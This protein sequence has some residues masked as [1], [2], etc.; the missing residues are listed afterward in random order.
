M[1]NVTGS[2]I[3]GIVSEL[4]QTRVFPGAPLVRIFLM[5]GVLGG[6]TT[7]S[8]YSLETLQLIGDRNTGL[9]LAYALGSV[10]LGVACAFGG[11]ILA[12]SLSN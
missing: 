11:V 2:F 5:T 3:I 9:A 10:V 12:R 1:I 7:F 4:T 6:Y 8:T